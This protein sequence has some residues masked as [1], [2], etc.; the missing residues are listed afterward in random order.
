MVEA[1]MNPYE[2]L[3]STTSK[4]AQAIGLGGV[5]GALEKGMQADLLVLNGNPLQD[6]SVLADKK[7]IKMVIKQGK[8]LINNM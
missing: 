6:I 2:A 1:G 8:I 7:R 5:T 3:A 4:A